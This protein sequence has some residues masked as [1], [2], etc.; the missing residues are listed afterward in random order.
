[1]GSEG[2]ELPGTKESSEAAGATPTETDSR[3]SEQPGAA[4]EGREGAGQQGGWVNSSEDVQSDGPNPHEVAGALHIGSTGG[5]ENVPT[6]AGE[7]A[8]SG[9]VG[10]GVE[11][12]AEWGTPEI[13]RQAQVA[14][15]Q[16]GRWAEDPVW[17]SGSPSEESTMVMHSV[18]NFYGEAV[19]NPTPVSNPH[20]EGVMADHQSSQGNQQGGQHQGNQEHGNQQHGGHQQGSQGRQQENEQGR[21]QGQGG[22]LGQ[23]GSQYD[24]S[25]QGQQGSQQNAFGHEQ[26]SRQAALGDDAEQMSTRNNDEKSA[27]GEASASTGTTASAAATDPYNSQ[28]PGENVDRALKND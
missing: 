22:R 27:Y 25:Q 1:M 13:R 7:G 12:Q 24:A 6:V 4:G 20:E 9:S 21:Q 23:Q 3:T 10:F 14:R 15:E 11:N 16:G 18:E 19:I 17:E 5:Y 26:E 8:G 2:R 28:Q